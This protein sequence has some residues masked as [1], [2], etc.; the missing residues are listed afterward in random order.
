M[1]T[2]P[3]EQETIFPVNCDK[4]RPEFITIFPLFVWLENGPKF[5]INTEVL[6][7]SVVHNLRILFLGTKPIAI[8]L[9]SV[10][11]QVEYVPVKVVEWNEN[12][13]FWKEIPFPDK[14]LTGVINRI[15]YYF[16]FV[17]KYI[18]RNKL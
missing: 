13:V 5:C 14:S 8:P 12:I 16:S 6:H 10:L 1:L 11:P 15:A 9:L 4:P 17:F 18:K 7:A 3:L 2:F